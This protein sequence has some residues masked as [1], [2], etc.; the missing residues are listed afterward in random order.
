MGLTKGQGTIDYYEKNLNRS[1]FQ[2]E[3]NL[4][5]EQKLKLQATLSQAYN[6]PKQSSYR[7]DYFLDNCSSRVRDVVDNIVPN[8]ELQA[9][10]QGKPSGA[11]FRFHTDRCD[12]EAPWLYVLLKGALGHPVDQPID[13]WDEMFLP[14]KLHDRLNEVRVT[15]NGYEMPLVASDEVLYKSTRPPGPDRP[16]IMTPWLLA[17]GVVFGGALA[18]LAGLVRRHWAARWGFVF[19]S[20]PWLMLM[21]L[22]GSL[23]IWAWS[24]TDHIVCRNNENVMHVSILAW[25][26]LVLV[27]MLAFGKTRRAA[28]ARRIAIA[29]VAISVLGLLLKGLPVFYQK[30]WPIIALCLPVNAAIAYAVWVMGRPVPAFQPAAISPGK[31]NSKE[32]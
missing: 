15:V 31:P 17:V 26:L 1:V 30:N 3:L 6:D 19:L 29:M 22:G 2:Q 11:T 14:E 8:H 10:T 28:L 9:I 32:L 12:A 4:S 24:A 5:F 7:Y 27:P 18:V 20:V 13:R 25:P 16:P 23:L 21:S